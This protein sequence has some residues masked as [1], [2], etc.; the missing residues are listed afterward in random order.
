MNSSEEISDLKTSSAKKN[1]T[2]ASYYFVLTAVVGFYR[3]IGETIYSINEKMLDLLIIDN[4]PIIYTLLTAFLLFYKKKLAW[5]FVVFYCFFYILLLTFHLYGNYKQSENG[6]HIF[7]NNINLNDVTDLFF[8]FIM[9]AILLVRF[10][11]NYMTSFFHLNRNQ[12]L[13]ANSIFFFLS[14]LIVTVIMK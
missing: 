5:M 1:C 6:F 14:L 8:L 2:Y 4:L 13:K 11:M 10:N 3:T 12:Q 9:P 7:Q